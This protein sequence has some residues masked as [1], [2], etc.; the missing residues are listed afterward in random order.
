MTKQR[1]RRISRHFG[2]CALLFAMGASA[3]CVDLNVTSL[4]E[5][6][7]ERVLSNPGSL[8]N[9]FGSIFQGYYN[10]VHASQ[11]NTND[12]STLFPNY[13]TEF[14][15]TSTSGG[16]VYTAQTEPRPELE[17][18]VS[19]GPLDP[20]GPRTLWTEL[21]R[22]VSIAYDGLVTLEETGFVLKDGNV[23]V[24][25]RSRAY[26]KLMQGMLWG[27]LSVMYDQAPILH[28]GIEIGG[29][30]YVQMTELLAPHQD[31][32]AASLKAFDD[33]KAIAQANTFSFPT[34]PSLLWFGTPAPMTNTDLIELANTM[35]AR[36]IILN[37]RTPAERKAVDWNRVLQLTASGLTK[38]FEVTLAN[39]VRTSTL[40]ATAQSLTGS[41]W[42]YR[43]IGQADISGAY[44][45]WAAASIASRTRFNIV[46][47]DRRITGPT[48]T[49]NGSYTMYRSDDQGFELPFG[50][51]LFS[52]YQ[53]RRHANGLGLQ[54]PLTGTDQGRAKLA[55]VDE[56]RLL[57][58]EAMLYR[59]D[60]AGAR[61]LINV[62]RTRQRVIAGVTYP[63][64]PPV[65]LTGA[66]H[67]AAGANDCVPR[68]D[69]GLCG[70]L[71]V[72]LR[73]ERMIELA[74][75]DQLRGYADSRG[76]GLLPNG[77]WIQLPLPGNE[78]QLVGLPVTTFG[79]AGGES[80]AVYA[81]VTMQNAQ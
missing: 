48:P 12:R 34:F 39:Q 42:N 50:T 38:D 58:A 28:E 3:S 77:S 64:L 76:F 66:P 26:A 13:A 59:G 73:Y 49:S 7:R 68:T 10:A 63:G 61:D 37:A 57:R 65:T 52:A 47:P 2:A 23:D 17:N 21:L 19:L 41:R 18:S 72:A 71:M 79:G 81:P 62:T 45:A 67:S 9:L 20:A 1:L 15:S 8:L 6:D 11:G 46:T 43:L 74:G 4:D 25:Q 80:S 16:F 32:L 70:D 29:D 44:Q 75:L 69:S 40:F 54:Q 5:A 22:S 55:T 60:L 14:T 27:Y 33:A 78:A 30:S 36:F 31:V 24:T 35:A 51:H 56:N 53:W